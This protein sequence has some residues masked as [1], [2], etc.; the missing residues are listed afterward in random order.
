MTIFRGQPRRSG[1]DLPTDYDVAVLL[2]FGASFRAGSGAAKV[3]RRIRP[4]GVLIGG[5]PVVPAAFA[6][7]RE[8]KVRR[9][10]ALMGHVVS[11]LLVGSAHGESCGFNWSF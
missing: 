10:A 8:S 4:G 1:L 3:A 11:F 7:L 6:R 5:F 2:H 9:T